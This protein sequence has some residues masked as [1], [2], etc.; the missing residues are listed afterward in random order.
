V[1]PK[2]IPQGIMG[3][4]EHDLFTLINAACL[5]RRNNPLKHPNVFLTRLIG[6]GVGAFFDLNS[7]LDFVVAGHFAP[8][9]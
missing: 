4:P 8:P 2:G 7:N 3:G 1:V 5:L 9:T 6:C